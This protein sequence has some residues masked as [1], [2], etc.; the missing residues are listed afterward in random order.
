MTL[1]E[2]CESSPYSADQF[3][4]GTEIFNSN[5]YPVS[6]GVPTLD[7]F[8]SRVER[9]LINLEKS[10]AKEKNNER[11][12]RILSKDPTLEFKNKLEKLLQEGVT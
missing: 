11:M 5:F 7:I 1:Q 9:D 3:K 12:Y 2:L 10:I 6:S 8:Q 4:Y